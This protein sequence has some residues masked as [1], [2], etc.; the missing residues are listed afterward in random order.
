MIR[1]VLEILFRGTVLRRRL[2]RSFGYRPIFLSPDSALSYLKLDWAKASGELLAAAERFVTPGAHVW[3]VGGNVGVFTVA[4]AHKA[5]PNGEIITIE[6][7]PFLASL[8]LRTSLLPENADRNIRVICAAASDVP[9]IARF[10]VAK[11]GRSSSSLE[12][13]G[14]RSQAGGTRYVQYV[15]TITLDS[16]LTTFAPPQVLKIDVEGAEGLV[17]DGANRLLDECRPLLYI[18]VGNEQSPYVTDVLR[19][20]RYRLYDG[21]TLDGAE[22]SACTFNTL[23]VPNESSLTNRGFEEM[24]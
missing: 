16:L 23:A 9:T 12:Q 1:S 7:D 4:A 2:P 8:V 13:A 10:M 18:E 6:A 17:L 14:H 24:N 3:D 21:D 19:R 11:R 5:G 22:I 20:H 15:P